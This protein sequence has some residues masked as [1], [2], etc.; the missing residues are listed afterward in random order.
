MCFQRQ[1]L[2]LMVRCQIFHTKCVL[3]C[4][5]DKN[6]PSL[7]P[8][9]FIL[10]QN[11]RKWKLAFL[12]HVRIFSS[13][14]QGQGL[15]QKAPLKSEIN[16]K[17]TTFFWGSKSISLEKRDTSRSHCRK[18]WWNS[19]SREPQFK[20]KSQKKLK[21][22]Q[23]L[24]LKTLFPPFNISDPFSESISYDPAKAFIKTRPSVAEIPGLKRNI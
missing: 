23:E 24:F 6:S 12:Q 4:S 9:L 22:P 19:Q 11:R 13:I 15:P 18:W 14:W 2:Y 16:F 8:D 21:F 17:N 1:G 10:R 20:N 5:L 7:T 3:I